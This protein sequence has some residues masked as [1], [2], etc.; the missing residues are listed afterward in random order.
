MKMQVKQVN[1]RAAERGDP[2]TKQSSIIGENETKQLEPFFDIGFS[3]KFGRH[4]KILLLFMWSLLF[5]GGC[6]WWRVAQQ[7]VDLNDFCG[8]PKLGCAVK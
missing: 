8:V 5:Y 7:I 4:Y 2:Q 6:V 1:N 3:S